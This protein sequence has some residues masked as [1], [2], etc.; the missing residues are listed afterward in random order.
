MWEKAL[1]HNLRTLATSQPPPSVWP[2]WAEGSVDISTEI[3]RSASRW[4]DARALSGRGY[5]VLS[6][7]SRMVRGTSGGARTLTTAHT[8]W[9]TQSATAIRPGWSAGVPPTWT[10]K[11]AGSGGQRGS[12][13]QPKGWWFVWAWPRGCLSHSSTW[14][15][16]LCSRAVAL[17]WRLP[18][19]VNRPELRASRRR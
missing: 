5:R 7:E 1:C 9:A 17:L 8:R 12:S 16:G 6:R 18:S 2:T 13:W 15:T 3:R 4:S 10:G 14:Q 19:T 11:L